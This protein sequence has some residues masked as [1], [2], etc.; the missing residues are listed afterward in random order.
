MTTC[1]FIFYEY[2]LDNY[3][4]I[5]LILTKSQRSFLLHI[6]FTILVQSN[7]VDFIIK[8]HSNII[9]SISEKLRHNIKLEFEP[10][11]DKSLIK[12]A[13]KLKGYNN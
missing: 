2:L 9:K 13:D 3:Q 7:N 12:I 11:N 10:A 6:I 8:N 5:F 4:V 1:L